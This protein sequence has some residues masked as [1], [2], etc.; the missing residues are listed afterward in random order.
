MSN[1]LKLLIVCVASSAAVLS[2]FAVAG[3][4]TAVPAMTGSIGGGGVYVVDRFTGTVTNCTMLDCRRV[5][6]VQ[7]DELEA[8]VPKTLNF[9]DLINGTRK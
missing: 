8:L 4:Y 1:A 5:P 7:L 3:R 6:K 2:A 9:D